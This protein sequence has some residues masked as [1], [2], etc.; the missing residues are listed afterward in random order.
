[1]YIYFII[2]NYVGCA[3]CQIIFD[4]QY[5]SGLISCRYYCIVLGILLIYL[6][7]ILMFANNNT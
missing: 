7:M 1:M 4:M 5:I 2:L 3:I 6:A